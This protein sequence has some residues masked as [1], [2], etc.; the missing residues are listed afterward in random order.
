M[1]YFLGKDVDVYWTTEAL[2]TAISGSYDATSTGT[3]LS[4]TMDNAME[5]DIGDCFVRS[6]ENGISGTTQLS[7]ITGVD[8]TPG[9]MSEDISFMGKNTNLSAQIKHEFSLTLTKK[10][11]DLAWDRLFNDHGRDGVYTTSGGTIYADRMPVA[12]GS[13]QG[14][15]VMHDGLTTSRI[16]NFGY[17]VYLVLKDVSEVFV[18]KNCCITGHTISLNADGT[19]E[20]SLELYSYVK[21]ALTNT[22]EA[23]EA[24]SITGLTAMTDI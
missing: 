13:E 15:A 22:K 8:F 21:P 5:A 20:E 23:D 17:R 11:N 24:H 3:T 14:V 2:Y 4:G 1:A 16:Q 18:I 19:Q 12:T 6:R 7:D 9:A 10:K